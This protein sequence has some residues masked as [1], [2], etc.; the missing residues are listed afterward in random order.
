M[1]NLEKFKADF[2]RL[3]DQGTNLHNAMRVEQM[4]EIIE[5]HF[6][7]VLKRDYQVFVKTLPSFSKSYQL[8]YSEALAL[9][10]VLLPGRLNDFVAL[11]EQP[12]NRKQVTKESYRIEDYLMD[13][14][15]LGLENK[16]LVGPIHAIP[17]FEQQLQILNSLK[18]RF[19]SSL[20]NIEQLIRTELLDAELDAA[21]LLLKNKCFRSAG[22]ICGVVLSKHLNQISINHQIKISKKNP[23]ITFLNDLLRKQEVYDVA[24][25]RFIQALDDIQS[26]CYHSKKREPLPEEINDLIIGVDK[27]IKTVW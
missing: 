1:M 24:L 5:D 3:I 14:K 23:T 4:P 10:K 7:N 19:E 27:M 25:W 15:I 17:Q 20:L 26:L 2:K 8:W 21:E 6:V 9:I 22:V 16:V 18:S 12:K 11:Y 13:V